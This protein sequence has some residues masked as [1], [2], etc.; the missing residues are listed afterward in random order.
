MKEEKEETRGGKEKF[1]GDFRMGIVDE[2]E[3]KKWEE[4]NKLV[5]KEEQINIERERTVKKR[6][7]KMIQ[8]SIEVFSAFSIKMPLTTEK[9]NLCLMNEF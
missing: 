7:P 5:L 8:I 3:L 6:E 4:M 1:H 2:I 9:C